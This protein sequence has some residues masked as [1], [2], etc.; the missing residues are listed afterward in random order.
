[1]VTPVTCWN[2]PCTPQKQPPANTAVSEAS[3]G[4]PAGTCS[5]KR[6]AGTNWAPSAAHPRSAI[7]ASAATS[8]TLVSNAARSGVRQVKGGTA[9]DLDRC[10][11]EQRPH[12]GELFSSAGSPMRCSMKCGNGRTGRSM[13]CAPS[14]GRRSGCCF[15]SLP[16]MSILVLL[17]AQIPKSQRVWSAS[18]P[19]NKRAWYN[20]QCR[21]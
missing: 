13:E 20:T 9:D 1:L 21:C 11:G 3:A 10:A 2:T 15:A 6:G 7:P 14:G 16:D 5:S 17:R 18:Q 8:R 4:A 19:P 12:A